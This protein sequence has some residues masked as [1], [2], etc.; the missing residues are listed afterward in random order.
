ME[1]KI[2]TKSVF[3]VRWL[4]SLIYSHYIAA[5]PKPIFTKYADT[6]GRYV[7]IIYTSFHREQTLSVE[8]QL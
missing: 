8:N 1:H 4:R 3:I 2:H 6:K 5:F 7:Q